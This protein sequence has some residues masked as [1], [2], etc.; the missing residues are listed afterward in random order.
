VVRGGSWDNDPE[1]LRS[2]ARNGGDAGSRDSGLGF[3][4]AQDL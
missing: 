4:L 1:Y 3:R 2:A